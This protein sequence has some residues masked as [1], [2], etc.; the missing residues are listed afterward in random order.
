MHAVCCQTE[1]RLYLPVCCDTVLHSSAAALAS[2]VSSPPATDGK[3]RQ[4]CHQL[5]FH[6]QHTCYL[7]CFQTGYKISSLSLPVEDRRIW[8]M[9]AM[10]TRCMMCM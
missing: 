3:S 2:T 5:L 6:N 7:P 10:V 9:C 4:K 1:K 8:S